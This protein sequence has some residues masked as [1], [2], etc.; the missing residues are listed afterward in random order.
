[1][2]LQE[3]KSTAAPSSLGTS[4]RVNDDGHDGKQYVRA[5]KRT[6]LLPSPHWNNSDPEA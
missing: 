2:A 3:E 1:M 6:L 5:I 4:E